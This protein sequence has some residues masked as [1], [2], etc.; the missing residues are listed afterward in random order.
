M[1]P[2]L[3]TDGDGLPDW[4]EILIGTNPFNRDT[5]GDGLTDFEEVFIYHT[6]PL[7]RDTD[8]DGF[9]DGEEVLLGSDP[10]DPNSTPLSVHKQRLALKPNPGDQPGVAREDRGVKPA[11]AGEN[12]STLEGD[13]HAKSRSKKQRPEKTAGADGAASNLVPRG[14]DR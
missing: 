3:D 2:F 8:G 14:D 13:A 5:D 1:D 12:K 9:T 7:E 6:N 10:L 11:N 4:F